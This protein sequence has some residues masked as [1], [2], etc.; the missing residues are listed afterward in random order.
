MACDCLAKHLTL[1]EKLGPSEPG[2]S[3]RKDPK[4]PKVPKPSPFGVGLKGFGIEGRPGKPRGTPGPDAGTAGGA[5]SQMRKSCA[6]LGLFER[7]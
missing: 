1:P 2:A 4:D 3:G 7:Q 6:S 5:S